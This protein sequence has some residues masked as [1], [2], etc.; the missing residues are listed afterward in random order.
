MLS[1]FMFYVM[2]V[3]KHNFSNELVEISNDVLEL[4]HMD[5]N[6]TLK[7]VG[8]FKRRRILKKQ[9]PANQ[10]KLK[11]VLNKID[12]INELITNSVE[13]YTNKK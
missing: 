6:E 11:K 7:N 5:T 9:R 4:L 1:N 12:E 2:V 13:E 3:D 10:E 8:L